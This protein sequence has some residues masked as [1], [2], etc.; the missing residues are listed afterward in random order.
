MFYKSILL[1]I[2][3]GCT[4]GGFTNNTKF[5]YYHNTE[6]SLMSLGA[7]NSAYLRIE[8]VDGGI[9][10]FNYKETTRIEINKYG[11]IMVK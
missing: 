5:T 6:P 10:N 3:S 7:I 9:N 8:V 2:L 11:E 1:I 4:S